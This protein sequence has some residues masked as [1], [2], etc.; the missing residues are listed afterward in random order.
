M[1]TLTIKDHLRIALET[2]L[3]LIIIIASVILF[4]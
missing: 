2:A 3:L 1:K 4:I